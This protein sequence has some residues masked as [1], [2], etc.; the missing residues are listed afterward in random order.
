MSQIALTHPRAVAPTAARKP[1]TKAEQVAGGLRQIHENL[2]APRLRVA[3]AIKG[4]WAS[5]AREIATSKLVRRDW[6]LL[7]GTVGDARRAQARS[8]LATLPSREVLQPLHEFAA[9]TFEAPPNRA[10]TRLLVGLMLDSYPNARPHAP[11][12]YFEALA[13]ELD[14]SGYAPVAIACALREIVRKKAFV[15]AI[16]EVLEACEAEASKLRFHANALANGLKARMWLEEASAVC[17]AYEAGERYTP[18]AKTSPEP[19][20]EGGPIPFAADA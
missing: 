9:M 20:K 10:Q 11:E 15:P 3:D 4:N 1:T 12:T 14:A 5:L 18:P 16:A 17:A 2:I 7:A 8:D 6:F 13:H 19:W